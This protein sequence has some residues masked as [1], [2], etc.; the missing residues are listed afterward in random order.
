MRDYS[1]MDDDLL[2]SLFLS[3]MAYDPDDYGKTVKQLATSYPNDF[4]K[5]YREVEHRQ[6][7]KKPDDYQFIGIVGTRRR[8]T[9]EDLFL[10][11]NEVNNI[12]CTIG[13]KDKIVIVSGLCPKGGDRF[14]TLIYQR[15]KTKKLWFPPEWNLGRHAGF[16]RNTEIAR[17]SD[18]LIAVVSPDRKGGTEDTIKKFTRFHGPDTLVIT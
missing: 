15:L 8:D 4:W 9:A 3:I 6:I 14:A 17:W 12:Q 10:I 16:V 5:I 2:M 7:Y 18:Y 13:L 11:I 1:K